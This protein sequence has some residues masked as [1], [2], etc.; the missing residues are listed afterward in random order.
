MKQ[1]LLPTML[2]QLNRLR[3]FITRPVTLG[4][5][6]ILVSTPTDASRLCHPERRYAKAEGNVILSAVEGSR[7]SSRAFGMTSQSPG[8]TKGSSGMTRSSEVLLVQHTYQP[9]WFLP[10]GR[11]ERHETPE[12]AARREAAEEVGATLGALRLF[13]LY[14]N[15]YE[16]K[17]DH[18]LVFTCEDF[19]LT[20]QGDRTRLLEGRPT[21]K[22]ARLEIA[23]RAF[24]DI[25]HLPKDISPGCR[26]RVREYLQA[27]AWPIVG[28]W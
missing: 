5:R 23:Q 17:S 4:V 8:T 12:A 26:R 20:G 15:F 13:G 22:L 2:Y 1:S 11:I 9:Y 28:D 7:D 24:F 18:I 6:L 14:T 21:S 19:T 27:P 16:H 3:H 25:T 10:G